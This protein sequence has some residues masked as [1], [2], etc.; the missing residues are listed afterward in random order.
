MS[1]YF[2]NAAT[3]AINERALSSYYDTALT[4]FANPSAS[5]SLGNK[6]KECLETV[7][8]EISNLL[9]IN[10]SNIYFTSGGTESNSIVL[11]SLLWSRSKTPGE[12]IIN[13][14]E[15]ASV[16]NFE[17]IL[18]EKGY[19]VIK[20]DAPN[21][22]VSPSTLDNLI[23]KNTKMVLI[24]TVN[25]VIGSINDIKSLVNVVRNK[26]KEINRKIHFHTDAVQALTKIEFDLT[27]LDVDSAS[28]SAH[29]FHGPRGIGFLYNK[30]QSLQALS[31]GGN[32][33]KGLRAGTENLAAIVAMKVALEEN[34]Q[35]NNENVI[36]INEY[37]RSNLK[38]K[39]LSPSSNC[40]PFIINFS[41]NNFPSEVFTRILDD[42]G[43]I[44]SSGSAC[45]NNVKNKGESI[46]TSMNFK[47]D[48]AK[49]SIRISFEKNTS[50]ESV[51]SL[52][53]KINS[54]YDTLVR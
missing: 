21:G 16:S 14:A 52:V 18:V 45:S 32:Q 53:T 28:F 7:R 39:I 12:V 20:I 9:K 2:D 10:P 36:K 44:V 40:S 30:S 41:V 3:T 22:F 8:D 11:S 51:V 46:L 4:Y 43:F 42:E 13:K 38:P 47:A 19:K 23:N 37:V 34:L 33:E 15:H 31:R 49:S 29:K 54:L 1:K 27:D 25:N 26:E 35:L 48:D 6:A 17:R 24:Q 50:Y 5:H